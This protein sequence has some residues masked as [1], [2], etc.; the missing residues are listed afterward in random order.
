MKAAVLLLA[1]LVAYP[2][3]QASAETYRYVDE[4]GILCL[5][6]APPGPSVPRE[7]VPEQKKEAKTAQ[8]Q[9]KAAG[10]YKKSYLST[11]INSKAEK[12]DLDPRL[13]RA[14]IA[15]ES[16]FDARAVSSK[17][18]MGLMQLMPA[19]ASDMG[20]YNPFNA[21]DNIEGGVRYLKYLLEKFGGDLRLALAAYNAGPTRVEQCGYNVPPIKET[22]DYVK[23][24]FALYK[25]GGSLPQK[26]AMAAAEKKPERIYKIVLNDGTVLYTNSEVHLKSPPTF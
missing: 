16:N 4:N 12:Y 25:G 5:S 24:V 26:S 10:D 18:A 8:A 14:V 6:D 21:E 15:V 1:L 20:V 22:K 17:G 7:V 2:C 11:L 13:V 23:K 19:T 9:P 3:A